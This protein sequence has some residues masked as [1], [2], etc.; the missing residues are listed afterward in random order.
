LI[1]GEIDVAIFASQLD[2]R[3]LQ[4]AL[5]PPGLRLMNVAQ[6]EAIAKTV[7]G[8]KHLV[9]SRGIISLTRDIP[10]S[11]IDLLASKSTGHR[12][13]LIGSVNFLLSNQMICHSLRRQ[14]HFTA[15]ARASGNGTR[16][17]G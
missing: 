4:R 6:A 10:N 3:F 12:A 1:A 2:A 14:R 7:P 16:P 15:S 17:S 11:D 13:P 9:L 8:L 5:G